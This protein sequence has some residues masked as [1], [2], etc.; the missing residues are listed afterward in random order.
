MSESTSRL[1][2]IE[3]AVQLRS[4]SREPVPIP[5]EAAALQQTNAQRNDARLEPKRGDGVP[6]IKPRTDS[7]PAQ[8]GKASQ[9][10]RLNYARLSASRIVTPDNK[11]SATYNE[12][13]ALKRKLIPMTR[14]P[15]TGAMT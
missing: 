4:L 5:A 7:E 11:A 13:R 1:N 9:P 8:M 10:V 3:R 15:E 6:P 2:L 12:F 14:D